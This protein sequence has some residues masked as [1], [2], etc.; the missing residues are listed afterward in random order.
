MRRVTDVGSLETQIINKRV[1][2]KRSSVT[3]EIRVTDVIYIGDENLVTL[4]FL[5]TD[6][7]FSVPRLR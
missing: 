2:D 5:V 4:I 1:S 7:S 3:R 6:E